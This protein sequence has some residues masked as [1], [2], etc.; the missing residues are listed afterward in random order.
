MK[1]GVLTVLLIFIL[2]PGWAQ[3]TK[4]QPVP[5]ILFSVADRS[6][7]TDE[8][9]YLY[10]KNHQNKT[11]DYTKAKIDEYLSLF[12]N[13]KLKVQE[14]RT[15]GLDTTKVFQNEFNSYKEEL[16]RPYLPE[17]KMVDSLVQLTYARLKEEVRAS[18]ILIGVKPEATPADTLEA[19]TRTMAIKSRA[20]AGED[21]GTLAATLSEDPSARSNQG[22][23]GYFT[24]L[25]MVYPFETAAYQGKPG[26]VV[27]PV[28]TRFGYHLVKILDRKPARGEVE[29]SH[30]MIRIVS[31]NDQE[32]AKN[33][34]FDVYDELKGG[35][36]WEELCAQ[37]SDDVSTKNS[38]GRLR[39]FGVGAMAT[40]PEFDQV[41]F[42]LQQPGEISDPFQTAYGWHIVRLEH[43]IPLPSFEEI[44]PSLKS[45]VQRDERV[46]IS[47]QA[48]AARL[49][50]E[51][52][53]KENQVAKSKVFALADS[54]LLKGKWSVTKL[55]GTET[56]FSIK[57]RTIPTNEFIAYVKEQQRPSTVS[58]QAYIEQL[59]AAF[60]ETVINQ[61]YEDQLVRTNPDYEMLLREYYEGIL[62][63][64]IMEKEVWNK[65]SNDTTGQRTY[66]TAHADAYVAGERVLAEIYS[67][68]SSENLAEM[69]TLLQKQDSAGIAESIKARKVRLE[70]GIYQVNDRPVLAK[71]ERKE[72]DYSV[73][74]NGMYYL[75]R[76]LQLISPGLMTFEEAKASVIS[77]YQNHLEKTWVEELG[78]KYAVKINEKGKQYMYK[79]LV[80]P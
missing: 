7:S 77:D 22:D 2:V 45:R 36:A 31:E 68:S 41:A 23:L 25:Q 61:A 38:G 15:R 52:A 11:D 56:L 35:V 17:G 6:V 4:K 13:F 14:A 40:V 29:V 74:N 49:K 57:S 51:Y 70:K 27:G 54:S 73:E 5:Q 67:T 12:I 75:V 19:Y 62:L 3:K 59:Y 44:A 39:P 9:I 24:A 50:K 63:F 78:R 80:R 46:Q 48:L 53:Y 60:V 33:I 34:I 66:F 43:K 71:V 18:H 21:F 37:Y 26:E 20:K 8:F 32:R 28:K 58:P 69:S 16:R 42:S 55:P 30:I 79:Q 64:D 1:C 65:A 47:R 10:K 76:I 72:G